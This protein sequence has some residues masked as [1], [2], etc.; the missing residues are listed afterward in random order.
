MSILSASD[1]T[2]LRTALLDA[3]RQYS[4][5][6]IFVSDRLDLR[7]N[8][9]VDSKA[10]QSAAFTLID[11]VESEGRVLEL[12]VALHTEKPRNPEVKKLMGR[13]AGL[14]Q[15]RLTLDPFQIGQND[16][17]LPLEL[18]GTYGDEQLE[19]FLPRSLSY[20]AD[21]GKL[22]R[23]LQ[24]S[25]SVCKISFVDRATLATGFLVGPDLVLTNYHVLDRQGTLDHE[26]LVAQARSL[27]CQFGFVSEERETPVEPDGFAPVVGDPVLAWSPVDKLDYVLLRMEPAIAEVDYLKPIALSSSGASVKP[28]DSLMV[29]QHPQGVE[30]Q[31]S[32]SATGVVQVDQQRGRMLYV[33][34]TQGGSSGSPCFN[35]DWHPVALHHASVA[36]GFGRVG[37]GILLSSIGAEIKQF[38]P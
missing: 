29:L 10:L 3:F 20:E 2:Q 28:Q 6:E 4:H 34:R 1:R 35:G 7:L 14:L 5:L 21:V 38:L 18:P 37:Q 24:L 25:D 19:S 31:V 32:L 26:G 13:V 17:D 36:K 22:R 9:I 30:M 27:R 16:W 23:G 11:Y 33:N 12:I 15:P 8:Q